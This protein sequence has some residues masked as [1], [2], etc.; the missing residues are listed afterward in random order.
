VS[1]SG[2]GFIKKLASGS[3]FLLK[4]YKFPGKE[5]FLAEKMGSIFLS[6]EL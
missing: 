6:F 3:G 1:V 5:W 4:D 2:A